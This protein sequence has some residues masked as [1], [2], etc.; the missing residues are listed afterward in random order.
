MS[1]HAYTSPP[2]DVSLLLRAHAEQ[3]LLSREVIPVLRQIETR[4]RLP[5]DQLPAALAYLEVIW[6]EASQRA[7]T[8]ERARQRLDELAGYEQPLHA[9]ACRY[10]ALLLILRDTV[11]R[12]VAALLEVPREHAP[13]QPALLSDLTF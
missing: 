8:T 12:R 13:H 4:E 5:E 6:A 7:H 2:P 3:R 11:A 9:R 10:H 1:D